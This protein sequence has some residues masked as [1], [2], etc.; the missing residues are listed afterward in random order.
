[1]LVKGK[2]IDCKR[3]VKE[4]RDKKGKSQKTDEKLFIS[5]AEV[6]LT[7]KQQKEL[8]DVFQGSGEKFTPEWVK[9]FQGYVNTSTKFELP[10]RDTDGHDFDSIEEY[11]EDGNAVLG[12][13]VILSLNLKDGAVYPK[14]IQMLT[15]GTPYN[16]FDE[17]DSCEELPFN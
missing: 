1:M 7:E 15:E 6:E 12:A 16:A 10:V 5:L 14:A 9:N 13:E 17:L 8:L 11:V 3:T 2:L 4:I